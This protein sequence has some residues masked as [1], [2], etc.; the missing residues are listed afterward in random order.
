MPG[1]S[2]GGSLREALRIA[3]R[4]DALL[5][6]G[7]DL[8]CGPIAS[9]DPIAR[10]N[11]WKEEYG[12]PGVEEN[13][14]SFWTKV[15]ASEGK[16]VLWFGRHSASELAFRH[17]WAWRVVQRRYQIVD[18]TGLRIPVKWGNGTDGVIESAQAVSIIPSTGLAILFDSERETSSD[19]EAS[20]RRQ[21]LTLMAEDASFRI[22]TPT[23]LISAPK[24]CF[25]PLLLAQS[26]TDWRK[27]AYVVANVLGLNSEPYLQMSDGTLIGRVAALVEQGKLV[28]DG[29][30]YEIMECRIRLP[31]P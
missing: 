27:V 29:D 19:E 31:K 4:D 13:I 18:V 15:D 25:D 12:W 30:P 24:D 11:W 17:A 2:A 8:S 5:V 7:D 1:D 22:I 9:G 16:L 6:F 28:A 26:A 10:A 21:W 3:G 23:G 14:R 20:Y